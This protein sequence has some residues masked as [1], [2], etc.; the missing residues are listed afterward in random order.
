MAKKPGTK[1]KGGEAKRRTAASKKRSSATIDKMLARISPQLKSK[2]DQLILT[3]EKTKDPAFRD[4]NLIGSKILLRAQEI[5]RNLRLSRQQ[6][7]K[8]K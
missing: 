7:G 1:K 2:I 4:M 5:S 3:L 8:K 6:S